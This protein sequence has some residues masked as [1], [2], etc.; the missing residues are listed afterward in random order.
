MATRRTCDGCCVGDISKGCHKAGI[1]LSL[2]LSEIPRFIG[3]SVS[4]ASNVGGNEGCVACKVIKERVVLHTL[5]ID[6][7]DDE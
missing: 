3:Y 5:S 4:C 2:S 1:A 6:L 7:S